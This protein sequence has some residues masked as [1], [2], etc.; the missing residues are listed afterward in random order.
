MVSWGGMG[1]MGLCVGGG[2]GGRLGG[3]E[4]RVCGFMGEGGL[5]MRMEEVG[6]V[7]EEKCGVKIILMKKN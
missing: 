3:G 1:S 6:R 7:M 5:E 2:I 4:G